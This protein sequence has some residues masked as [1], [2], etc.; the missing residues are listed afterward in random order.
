MC[1][2]DQFPMWAEM[3]RSDQMTHEQVQHFLEDHP[4]FA[5]WY[6]GQWVNTIGY[7]KYNSSQEEKLIEWAEENPD[8]E[9]VQEQAVEKIR[10][11]WKKDRK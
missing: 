6:E 11:L 2:I 10:A 7:E 9:W 5:A 8:N 1:D 4:G 3:I